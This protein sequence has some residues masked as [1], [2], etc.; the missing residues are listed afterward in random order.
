M[1][2]RDWRS[3]VD[4]S[5]IRPEAHLASVDSSDDRPDNYQAVSTHSGHAVAVENLSESTHGA[6]AGSE[7]VNLKEMG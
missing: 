6:A 7:L 1:S 2:S 5:D 4:A 3:V